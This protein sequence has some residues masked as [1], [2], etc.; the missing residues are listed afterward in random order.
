MIHNIGLLAGAFAVLPCGVEATAFNPCRGRGC[1][2]FSLTDVFDHVINAIRSDKWN[3]DF[4]EEDLFCMRC[5]PRSD[6][7]PYTPVTQAEDLIRLAC[8]T[9]CMPNDA[10]NPMCLTRYGPRECSIKIPQV[11]SDDTMLF[12]NSVDMAKSLERL[13]MYHN[14]RSGLVAYKTVSDKSNGDSN[15]W[16][17]KVIYDV[18]G[19]ARS[20]ATLNYMVTLNEEACGALDTLNTKF[21]CVQTFPLEEDLESFTADHAGPN[22][23]GDALKRCQNALVMELLVYDT[24][25]SSPY[26]VLSAPISQDDTKPENPSDKEITEFTSVVSSLTAEYTEAYV[27]LAKL[28]A[29]FEG[30]RYFFERREPVE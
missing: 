7:T 20:S 11:V 18:P 30:R 15:V 5:Q 24:F 25:P 12:V 3:D 10:S 29:P 9:W 16:E 22:C 8:L 21:R 27:A 23:Q 1:S 4:D 28:I 19:M 6:G 13:L 14:K 2:A 17:G 26:K